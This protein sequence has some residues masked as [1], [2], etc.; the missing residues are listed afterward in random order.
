MSEGKKELGEASY[1]QVIDILDAQRKERGLLPGPTW[2]R[3]IL[4]QVA[5]SYPV[6]ALTIFAGILLM[7]SADANGNV[8]KVALGL[9]ISLL[10]LALLVVSIAAAV[11]AFAWL[12]AKKPRRTSARL[13]V[14]DCVWMERLSSCSARALKCVHQTTAG[15]RERFRDVQKFVLGAAGK[16]SPFAILLVLLFISQADTVAMIKQGAPALV[17]LLSNPLNAYAAGLIAATLAY[18]RLRAQVK[19]VSMSIDLMLLAGALECIEADEKHSGGPEALAVVRLTEGHS[20]LEDVTPAPAFA[21]S[22]QGSV[23]Q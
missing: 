1:Q 4:D 18:T 22:S 13:M 23:A 10:L 6:A 14:E 21:T 8:L 16:I 9:G 5:E 17:P 15:Q 12:R 7:A 19:D 20:R 2:A 11:C 3:T